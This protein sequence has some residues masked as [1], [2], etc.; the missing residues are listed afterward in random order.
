MCSVVYLRSVCFCQVEFT[1]QCSLILLC[2][3][4]VVCCCNIF[5]LSLVINSCVNHDAA[6]VYQRIVLTETYSANMRTISSLSD[7]NRYG[8]YHALLRASRNGCLKET[9]VA[10]RMLVWLNKALL[11]RTEQRLHFVLCKMEAKRA[12]ILRY[13]VH[14]ETSS[15]VD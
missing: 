2:A 10:S 9:L 1:C 7:N 8:I 14:E 5:L 3:V 11:I 15:F 6:T 4:A 12:T 13:E